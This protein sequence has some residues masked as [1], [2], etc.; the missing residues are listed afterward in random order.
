MLF[1]LDRGKPCLDEIVSV[2][3]HGRLAAGAAED[4]YPVVSLPRGIAAVRAFFR[5]GVHY[6]ENALRHR[7]GGDQGRDRIHVDPFGKVSIGIPISHFEQGD[8]LC[9]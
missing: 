4:L 2:R 8:G 3:E 6:V 9:R 7:P 1:L 5:Q